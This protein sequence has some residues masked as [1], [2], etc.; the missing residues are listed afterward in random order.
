MKKPVSLAL[1]LIFIFTCLSLAGCGGNKQEAGTLA[2]GENQQSTSTD[3]VTEEGIDSLLLKG[4][5]VSGISYDFILTAKD[6]VVNGKV[7]MQDKQIKTESTVNGQ[8]MISIVTADSEVIIYNPEEKQA[9]KASTEMSNITDTPL[10]YTQDLQ[11]EK[12]KILESTIYDGARCKVITVT[13]ADG[14]EQSKMWIREDYGI[15][16]RVESNTPD[17]GQVVM[18]YKN[19]NV[20]PLPLDTF[21]LPEGVQVTDINKILKDLPEVPQVPGQ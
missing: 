17:S 15:P 3:P 6:G 9:F 21:K 13:S 2:T 5:Q 12:V 7:W 8:K 20:G 11:P 18:E 10:D 19:L 1:T 4:K 16:V 14:K